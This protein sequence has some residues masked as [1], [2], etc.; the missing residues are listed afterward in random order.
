MPLVHACAFGAPARNAAPPTT[1]AII[2]ARNPSRS[3]VRC[4]SFLLRDVS[5]CDAARLTQLIQAMRALGHVDHELA[6][7]ARVAGQR[8]AAVAVVTADVGAAIQVVEVSTA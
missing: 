7:H 3:V 6:V 2:A 5:R 4:M 1:A 8:G